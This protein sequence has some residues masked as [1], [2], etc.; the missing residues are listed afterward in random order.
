MHLFSKLFELYVYYNVFI[1]YGGISVVCFDSTY[2]YFHLSYSSISMKYDICIQTYVF[3]PQCLV[4]FIIEAYLFIFILIKGNAHKNSTNEKKWI[5]WKYLVTCLMSHSY[6]FA[7]QETF[8]CL[9]LHDFAIKIIYNT[10][11]LICNV[12]WSIFVYVS[13]VWSVALISSKLQKCG[14]TECYKTY[15][16]YIMSFIMKNQSDMKN[17]SWSMWQYLRSSHQFQTK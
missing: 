6:L 14:N 1:I 3:D 17:L 2:M 7:R 10:E 8:S 15:L 4:G 12:F 16:E 5:T 11:L 9:N 13:K